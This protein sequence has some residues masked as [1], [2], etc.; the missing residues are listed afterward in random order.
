MSMK[1]QLNKR[2]AGDM[3]AMIGWEGTIADWIKT[4]GMNKVTVQQSTHTHTH[5]VTVYFRQPG[6]NA[7]ISNYPMII[8]PSTSTKAAEAAV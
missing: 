6:T 1:A 2:E 7:Y 5:S 4:T 3:R 8:V